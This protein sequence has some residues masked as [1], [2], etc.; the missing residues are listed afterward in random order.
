MILL[1]LLF[2]ISTANA[3]TFSYTDPNCVGG[4][5]ITST[6][7]IVCLATPTPPTPPTPPVTSC[8][9]YTKT[10]NMNVT[11]PSAGSGQGA[12]IYNTD[13]KSLGGAAANFNSTDAL[14]IA[15]Q[16]IPTTAA[17]PFFTLGVTHAGGSSGPSSQRTFAVSTKPCDWDGPDSLFTIEGNVM[18]ARFSVGTPGTGRTEL[19][20]GKTYFLN[21]KN[22][23][24]GNLYCTATCNIFASPGFP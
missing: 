4:F 11:I 18:S 17:N 20:A 1:S 9:G 6:G 2:A 5:T 15:F 14:V 22:Y 12:R 19:Q 24:Y 8:Q 10:L 23:A 16:A 13:A 3:A 21:V 7:A